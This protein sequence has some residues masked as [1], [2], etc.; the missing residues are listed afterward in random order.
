MPCVKCVHP[1]RI[2]IGCLVRQQYDDS[3]EYLFGECLLHVSMF[4]T[5]R[6]ALPTEIEP[7]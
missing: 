7:G 1:M 5:T 2:R 3:R 4:V 6:V